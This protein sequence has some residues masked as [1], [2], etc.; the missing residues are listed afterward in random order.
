[1]L[2][3]D[4]RF[5]EV[6]MASQTYYHPPSHLRVSLINPLLRFLVLRFGFDTQGDQDV[7]RILRV[8]GRK[9]GLEY[10]VPVR[11]AFW[12]GDQYILSMLGD[13][14]WVRNLRALGSAQMIAGQMTEQVRAHEVLGEAKIAFLTWYCQHPQYATR[15]RFALG[16]DIKHFTPAEVERLADLY[17]V[18]RL[19]S[20]T[21]T[22]G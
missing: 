17:P 13:A 22:N 10:D 8:K 2:S 14:Q 19:E 1:M 9:S 18:F 16:A 4:Q 6:N 5:Q 7:M 3:L 20:E 15:V 21:Q 11:V 12:E